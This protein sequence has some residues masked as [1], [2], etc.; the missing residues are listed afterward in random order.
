ME[1]NMDADHRKYTKLNLTLVL[2]LFGLMTACSPFVGTSSTELNVPQEVS[3]NETKT[4]SEDEEF[5]AATIEAEILAQ[6]SPEVPELPFA[7]NPDPDQ[8]GIPTQWGKDGQAWLNGYYEGELIQPIVYLYDSHLRLDVK[9]KAPHGSEVQVVLYQSN[10][11]LDYYMVQIVG[12]Q[13]LD[14]QGWVPAPLLSFE[15]IEN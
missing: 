8:C 10:P 14:S 11:V 1:G 5:R 13:G 4:P 12:E 9:A 3:Q 15:P 7:D 6:R 2:G